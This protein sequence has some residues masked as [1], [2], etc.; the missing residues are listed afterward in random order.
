MAM[1]IIVVQKMPVLSSINNSTTRHDGA[2]VD[3]NRL[4]ASMTESKDGVKTLKDRHTMQVYSAL[5][6]LV[7]KGES[8]TYNQAIKELCILLRTQ[9]IEMPGREDGRLT[10][11]MQEVLNPIGMLAIK[12]QELGLA[13][14]WQQFTTEQAQLQESRL[15]LFRA[16]EKSDAINESTQKEVK[17]AVSGLGKSTLIGAGGSFAAGVASWLLTRNKTSG[18]KRSGIVAGSTIIGGAVSGIISLKTIV[19]NKLKALEKKQENQEIDLSDQTIVYTEILTKL[20]TL[21]PQEQESICRLIDAMAKQMEKDTLQAKGNQKESLYAD[22]IPP[23]PSDGY[24]K[25]ITQQRANPD[26]SIDIG[27]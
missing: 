26:T 19:G 8:E 9:V 10:H 11:D 7:E 5:Q 2:D 1:Q 6:S 15:P 22:K 27:Q 20:D 4:S 16:A 13:A 23:L 25:T 21:L 18:L 14:E 3:Y 12:A 24:A 17:E